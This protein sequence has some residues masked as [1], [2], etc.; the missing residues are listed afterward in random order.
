[1]A[2]GSGIE[3]TEATWN[4]VTG[5][6]KVSP[7]CKY[8]YAERMAMRLQAVG[9][10]NYANGFALTLQPHMLELPLRWKRP[11]TVFVNSMSDLFHPGVPLSYVGEVFAVMSRAHWHRFQVLTKRA[12]RLGE[13][14]P[15]LEW[16]PNVWMGV[17]VETTRYR[18]RIDRLRATGAHVK[19]LSLE[20][21]LGPLPD[22]DLRAIDWVIVGGE[23]GPAARAVDPRW[24]TDLRDQCRRAQ[25][26]FFF[27]QWGGRN[28]RLTG[29][30]LEGRTWNEMP[31]PAGAIPCAPANEAAMG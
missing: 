6:T 4:P 20:P 10:P 29:R 18:G 22:L 3:W 1:M 9:Q 11:Q 5:C 19:F 30:I 23:S 28:K 15:R 16:P 27:K 21:L 24:V 8:C 17:S 25:V 7:G 14:R 12:D 13:L 31:R 2:Q 26:P